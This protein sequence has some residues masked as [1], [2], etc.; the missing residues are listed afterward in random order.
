MSSER[1]MSTASGD[2]PKV[3]KGPNGH[4]KSSLLC[5]VCDDIIVEAFTTTKGDEAIFCE[6]EC[7]AW[8]HRRCAGLPRKAYV[9]HQVILIPVSTVQLITKIL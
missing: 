5:I 2:K 1:I 6:G 9:R 3:S 8:L 4:Q 7:Q